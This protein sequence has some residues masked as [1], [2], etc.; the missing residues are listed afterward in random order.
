M[1][2]GDVM[3]DLHDFFMAARR[4]FERSKN[5]GYFQGV[6]VGGDKVRFLSVNSSRRLIIS[7]WRNIAEVHGGTT[8]HHFYSSA[9]EA[10]KDRKL[11]G[12]LKGVAL[13]ENNIYFI[14]VVDSNLK[15]TIWKGASTEWE[16]VCQSLE[17]IG[18][19]SCLSE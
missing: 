13:R 11:P 4:A 15:K 6:T 18:R 17:E 14:S 12:A 8:F 7:L 1:G 5:S 3:I 19:R 10:F 2:K 9:E 16:K